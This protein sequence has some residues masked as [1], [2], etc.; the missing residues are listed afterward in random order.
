MT[1]H[2]PHPQAGKIAEVMVRGGVQRK[3]VHA[4]V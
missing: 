2:C 3:C 4:M 1:E